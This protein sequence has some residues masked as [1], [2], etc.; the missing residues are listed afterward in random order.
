MAAATA[1]TLILLVVLHRHLAVSAAAAPS[2][3]AAALLLLKDSLGKRHRLSAWSSPP[4][5][6]V[7][8]P[9]PGPASSASTAS[10]PASASP[11]WASPAP[12]TSTRSPASPASALS[13]SSNSLSGPLPA[14]NRRLPALK[15]LYLSGN[16]FSGPLPDDFFVGLAHLKKLWLN[17]NAFTGPPHRAAPR[18]QRFTGQLP[19]DPP[20]ALSEFN[21]SHNDLEGPVPASFKKFG[22]GAFVGNAYLC[23]GADDKKPCKKPEPEPEA[24][25]GEKVAMALVVLLLAA[26]AAAVCLRTCRKQRVRA[27]DTLGV[28]N[29]AV[30]SGDEKRGV[31]DGGGADAVVDAAKGSSQHNNS[32]KSAVADSVV[33][34]P[35][36][37]GGGGGGAAGNVGGGGGGGGLGSGDLVM[38]NEGKGRFGLADLMKAA[39]EV[40]GSGG[41][42]SAYKA[43]MSGGAGAAVV[44]KRMRDMNR[45][46]KETFD[47]EMRRLGRL[48]H[49]NVLPPLAFHYRKEEKL[50]VYEYIPK[51]SLLYV[52][53]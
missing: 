1:T 11:A 49:P 12:P 28:D 53:H 3:D 20:A 24:T 43:V 45:V 21:A 51:G 32:K 37:G 47:V 50:L 27:F 5:P 31:R 13:L 52:L 19:P 8:S 30:E 26:A 29:G 25:L 16:R 10:S 34:A 33:S 44:V 7:R 38:V 4:S 42:G 48:R 36:D 18:G 22:A 17:A 14:F 35:A 2:P 40:L 9:S 15:S 41:L 23:Y 46:G 6:P 39:A